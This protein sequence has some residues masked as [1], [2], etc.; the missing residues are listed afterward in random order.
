M[1]ERTVTI[2]ALSKTYSVTGWRVGWAV[3]AEPLMRGVRAAH[4]FMTVAAPTPL[5]IAGVTALG[6]PSSY[7]EQARAAYAER[8][9]LM[10]RTLDEAGFA[11]S[12]PEG[13]YY[14]MADVTPLGFDN[15]MKAAA[16]LVEKIGVGTVPGSSFFSDPKLGA[17]LLRFAFCKKLETLDAA[18]E[19][20]VQIGH[21]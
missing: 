20:L 12:A 15:D 18:A 4:D 1:R 8:R 7:Y 3:A 16:W 17:H 9:T 11:A 10:M 21:G 5:Q 6:L 2:S 14:V 19:R 13:A